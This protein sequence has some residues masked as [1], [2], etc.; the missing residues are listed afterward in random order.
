MTL[1][2]NQALLVRPGHSTFSELFY[3]GAAVVIGPADL[4]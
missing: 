3:K 1:N 4:P 2:S